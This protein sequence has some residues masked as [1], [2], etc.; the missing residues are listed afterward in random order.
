M[1][2]SKLASGCPVD[3]ASPRSNEARGSPLNVSFAILM[4]TEDGSI[5]KSRVGH[6]CCMMSFVTAPLPQP[7]SSTWASGTDFPHIAR[8][9][10]LHGRPGRADAH[11]SG[12]DI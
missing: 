7:T 6:R 1:T 8:A 5:P 3:A 4:N 11:R 9:Y 12:D 2:I 10:R